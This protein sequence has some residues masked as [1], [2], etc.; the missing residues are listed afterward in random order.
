MEK[1]EKTDPTSTEKIKGKKGIIFDVDNTL[2]NTHI[3]FVNAYRD[4]EIMLEEK[5]GN[6]MGKELMD[7][8]IFDMY[9]AK[10]KYKDVLDM[11]FLAE[12]FSEKLVEQ[13]LIKDTEKERYEIEKLL[14]GIYQQ[15]PEFLPGAEDLLRC[16]YDKGYKIGFCTHSG[17]SWGDVKMKGIWERLKFSNVDPVYLS[18]SL[19][20]QKGS[21]HW[22]ETVEMLGLKPEDVVVVGDNKEADILAAQKIGVDTCIWYKYAIPKDTNFYNDLDITKEGCVVY[23]KDTL[24]EIKELF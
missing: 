12:R 6:G 2:L 4:T 9:N 24:E 15:M 21:E 16:V 22:L 1:R 7:G 11:V 5:F 8:F 14:K 18:I 3:L 13:K 10:G 20:E 17:D 19:S 23:E